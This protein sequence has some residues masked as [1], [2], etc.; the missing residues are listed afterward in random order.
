MRATAIA[1]SML[2]LAACG[3][4]QHE[5]RVVSVYKYLGSVQCW[6]GGATVPALQSALVNSG[7]RVLSASCGVDGLAHPAVCGAPD[8]AIGIFD[9]PGSQEA[10]AEALGFVTL[11]ALP[12]AVRTSCPP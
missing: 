7:V 6:G 4:G 8:G 3:A 11:S 5:A 12:S 1:L 10:A 2:L 9:V